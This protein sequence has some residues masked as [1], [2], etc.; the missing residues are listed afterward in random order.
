[1]WTGRLDASLPLLTRGYEFSADLRDAAPDDQDPDLVW[2]RLF[3]RRA[4]LLR[5]PDAVRLFT[6]TTAVRRHGATPA[7]VANTL[8]G[9]GAVHGLDDGPHLDRKSLFVEATA[10][11]RVRELVAQVQRQWQ[12]QAQ[13]W[14]PSAVVTVEAEAVQ[15]LGRAVIAWAGIG[16]PTKEAE[17]VASWLAA[18]VDGFGTAGPARIRASRARRRANRW[19][20]EVVDSARRSLD[21][22]PDSVLAV[23]AGHRAT[24]G[25]LLPVS[26]AA[27]ELLNVLRPTVAVARFVA[28]AALALAQH[29]DWRATLRTED[30]GPAGRP[31]PAAVAFAQEV[32]RL[33]PFVPMLAARARRRLEFHGVDIP[34]DTLVLLDVVGLLRDERSW[35]NALQFQPDRFLDGHPIVPD[36][37]IPQGGGD[38]ATGHRC[39]GEDIALNLIAVS[40]A[41][42][43]RAAWRVPPQDLRVGMR[44]MPTRPA[45]GVRLTI[46]PAA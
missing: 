32:R 36:A 31:G 13:G 46:S 2:L 9:K 5:G 19:A 16:V 3:G 15:V 10:G 17:Q 24:D 27:V 29:A 25:S 12:V 45:S 22:P 11:H 41:H 33:A 44:R 18:I 6:D 42:L 30:D 34:E 39:P 1:M 37:L 23:V 21:T 26:T 8:F 38:V 4:C 14:T 28:F 7:V 20:E 40:A 43:A 35:P